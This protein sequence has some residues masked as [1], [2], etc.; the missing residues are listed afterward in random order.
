[1]HQSHNV[2]SGLGSAA[3]AHVLC[4]FPLKETMCVSPGKLDFTTCF[5]WHTKQVRHGMERTVDS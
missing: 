1:M 3:A 5:I 4:T 2:V